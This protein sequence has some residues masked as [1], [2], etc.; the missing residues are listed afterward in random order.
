M[1]TEAPRLVRD[2]VVMLCP[3]LP[4]ERLHHFGPW[5]LMPLGSYQGPWLSPEFETLART[6]AAAF[7]DS[8]GGRIDNPALLVSGEHGV[9]GALPSDVERQALQATIDL[10]FLSGNPGYRAADEESDGWRSLTSDNTEVYVQPLTP[11]GH[12]AIGR[13][14]IIRMLSGGH[15]VDDSLVLGAPQ[16]LHVP[17]GATGDEDVMAAAYAVFRGT[18][19]DAQRA[20]FAN[21][22]RLAVNWLSKAW[23]NTP[24]IRWED[25]IVLLKTG[26]EALTDTSKT[27]E[28][29][30]WL[31][32][33][34]E[35]HL[36]EVPPEL[37]DDLLWTTSE[38]RS[39]SYTYGDPAR[40][41]AVTQLEHWFHEFGEARNAI[42]HGAQSWP[43]T[44]LVD[45]PYKGLFVYVASR[46]LIEGIRVALAEFGYDR[47]WLNLA[48]RALS[49]AFSQGVT[50]ASD[51]ATAAPED[52]E[53]EGN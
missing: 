39:M 22:L 52:E 19:H 21:R 49:K 17:W 50:A 2:P 7:R 44:Y 36:A 6:Y 28:E 4:L 9:D 33:L 10:G 1:T 23:R 43:S 24:S 26:F 35:R 11:S 42:I 30:S 34:F 8:I 47:L 16:E 53:Q 51:G 38:S 45:G 18:H 31:R 37:L 40:T 13:G 25:R 14:L 32:S 48:T 29:A 46:L 20:N 5:K 27:H 12:L 3:Y 15:R 41:I